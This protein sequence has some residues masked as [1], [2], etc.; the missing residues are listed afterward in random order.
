LFN[1]RYSAGLSTENNEKK[2]FKTK[3]YLNEETTNNS[4]NSP[5]ILGNLSKTHS[6]NVNKAKLTSSNAQNFQVGIS[7]NGLKNTNNSLDINEFNEIYSSNETCKRNNTNNP[8]SIYF[9]KI[10]A[11]L[12]NSV[13]ISDVDFT[14]NGLKGK[15]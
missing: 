2:N 1:N 14:N 7:I 10:P 4:N 11:S 8:S 9:D 3:P 12:P 15:R 6:K 5:V 13:K